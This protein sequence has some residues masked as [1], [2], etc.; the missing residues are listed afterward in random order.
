MH[1]IVCSYIN[2]LILDAN[3][4]ELTSA[5]VSRRV[6]WVINYVRGLRARKMSNDAIN[7]ALVVIRAFISRLDSISRFM[8]LFRVTLIATTRL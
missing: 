7:P 1:V 6:I 5:P 4:E 8:A 2:A 3:A